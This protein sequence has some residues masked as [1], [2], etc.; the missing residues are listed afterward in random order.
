MAERAIGYIKTLMG[1]NGR[2]VKRF[3]RSR[4]GNAFWFVLLMIFGLFSILPLVYSVATSLKPLDELMLFPPRFFVRRVTFENYT[5]LPSLLAKLYVPFSRYLFNS[6]F[7]SVATTFLHII[8][9]AMASFVLAKSD[10]KGR[11]VIFWVVQFA[12]LYNVYTLSVP[13]Y[14]IFANLGM[15]DTYLVYILPYI[16][17]TMGVFLMKQFMEKSV[18]DSLLEAAKIDGAGYFYTFWRIVMPMVR[19]A[20]LTL[21]LFAFRDMWAIQ[22][23]GTVFNESL[24]TLPYAMG[25]ITAGGIA[26]AG[27]A[28]AATVILMIPPIIVFLISQS[29]VIETMSSAGIKE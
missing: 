15:I 28:M 13:Q 25:Q 24:K 26:R 21:A 18:P 10:L 11:N 12:L 4:S 5:A 20:W 3:T 29:N 27:S 16:P 22:P 6:V 14:L 17:S 7:V 1:K 23:Q 8:V 19:P 2:Q 9:A